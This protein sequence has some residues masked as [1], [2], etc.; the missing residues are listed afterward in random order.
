M[1]SNETAAPVWTPEA[2]ARQGSRS[3]ASDSPLYRRRAQRPAHPLT[4]G[5]A[6][7]T[8]RCLQRVADYF[9]RR[10]WAA[11]Y[12]RHERMHWGGG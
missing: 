5:F 4:F 2:A 8:G 9:S 6:D 1:I 12:E 11:E 7:A 10:L 3:S